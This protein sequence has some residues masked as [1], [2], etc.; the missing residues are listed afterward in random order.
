MKE[1][2]DATDVYTPTTPAKLNFVERD[3]INSQ[4]VNALKTPGKQLVVYGHSGSGKTTLLCNKLFQLYE[5]HITTRCVKGLTF[6]HIIIDAFNQLETYFISEY[7]QTTKETISASV[8]VK[9]LQIQGEV[10]SQAERES[11]S[12]IQRYLPPQ[13]TPQ[14]LAT[15]I[16]EANC[17]WVIEDFHKID[18]P[19]K[20][21][22]AQ[23]MKVFMDMSGD[24]KELKMIA[25]GA[26]GTAR[27]VVQYDP[28]MQ[29]RVSEVL[30][31]LI[32]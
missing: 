4:L 20:E 12:V 18:E 32:E 17:C 5:N 21:K 31:P 11:K 9:Y 6:D 28:E 8:G 23:V 13:L 7:T 29:N 24:Y 27:Q 16:G 15:L 19:E 14:A 30:V 25:I 22:L 2:V 10:K 1:I 3:T 26:V